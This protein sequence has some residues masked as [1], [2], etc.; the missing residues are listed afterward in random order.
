MSK[1]DPKKIVVVVSEECKQ[2][3]TKCTREELEHRIKGGTKEVGEEVKDKV[4]GTLLDKV[5]FAITLVIGLQVSSLFSEFLVPYFKLSGGLVGVI[6]TMLVF[7]GILAG[8]IVIK[9]VIKRL[10]K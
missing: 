5:E 2:D 8:F 4:L 6:L 3:I 7:I 10:T 1:E 9:S